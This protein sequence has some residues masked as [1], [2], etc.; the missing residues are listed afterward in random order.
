MQIACIL[1]EDGKFASLVRGK[2]NLQILFTLL[3]HKTIAF[4]NCANYQQLVRSHQKMQ[5]ERECDRQRERD[6]KRE[7][8]RE[9]ERVKS[10]EMRVHNY[11]LV[12]AH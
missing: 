11:E 1:I 5:T 4:C 6:R 8:G 2:L 3:M 10:W 12:I 9:R 7:R